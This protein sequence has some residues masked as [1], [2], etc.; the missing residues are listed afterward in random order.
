MPAPIQL[1][2]LL[3]EDHRADA[4]LIAEIVRGPGRVAVE[5]TWVGTLAEAVEAVGERTFDAV[6][7]D[8][9]L[10]DARGVQGVMHLHAARPLPVIV[11]TGRDADDLGF[12]ALDAGASDYL[13]KDHITRAR[14]TRALYNAVQT[15]RIARDLEA[16]R[17][18]LESV[19]ESLA[20]A[21][22]VIDREG[23]VQMRN[24]A[25]ERM[26]GA[27]LEETLS[28]MG[29][30]RYFDP[31]T[32]RPMPRDTQPW[33][34]ARRGEVV[35]GA[36]IWLADPQA[37]PRPPG[38]GPGHWLS[39]NIRPFEVDGRLQGGVAVLRDITERRAREQQVRALNDELRRQIAERSRAVVALEAANR[40]KAQFLDV[41][42]HEL[43]TPLTPI[44]G[45]ARLLLRESAGL[46]PD[47]RDA[48]RQIRDSGDRLQRVVDQV[49]EFQ[50]LRSEPI[51]VR[52]VVFEPWP[53]L[54]RLVRDGRQRAA[55]AVTLSLHADA[56]PARLVADVEQVEGIVERLLDNALTFT[57]HGQIAL[58][59]RYV[60]GR[61]LVEVRDSGVGIEAEHLDFIFGEFYQAEPSMTRRHGGLGLGLAQARFVAEALGGE[62][63]V[64]ST[65]GQGSAFRLAV[66]ATLPEG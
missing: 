8:L 1:S 43:R 66:P 40:L 56:L 13:T 12:A 22:V 34:R 27:R 18:L 16:Q 37:G 49:L 4:A 21:V 2:V 23:A 7:L 50:T 3:V 19:L 38:E 59:T 10:P 15:A 46:A 47:Q 36:E 9:S 52:P 28:A 20:D 33:S 32:R 42:S 63:G 41:V 17:N 35:D 31:A 64:R 5:L 57:P 62:L 6:L 26:L 65:P 44:L 29:E 58:W 11:L 60:D 61:W 25:A 53:L 24:P 14:L 54:E 48:V 39:A 30:S 55:E 45:Y 51:T